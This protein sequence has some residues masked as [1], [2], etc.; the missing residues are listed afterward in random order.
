MQTPRGATRCLR[1]G[2]E[3]IESNKKKIQLLRQKVGK[4]KKKCETLND[5]IDNLK[6]SRMISDVAHE[7]LLVS[8]EHNM[9]SALFQDDS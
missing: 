3:V 4:L 6:T 5:L 2:R 9:I 8:V 1:L 7:Q